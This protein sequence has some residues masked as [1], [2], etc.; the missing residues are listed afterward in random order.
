[1]KALATGALKVDK[2]SSHYPF[3]LTSGAPCCRTTPICGLAIICHVVV[4]GR[5]RGCE[6]VRLLTSEA[7]AASEASSLLSL[8]PKSH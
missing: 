6:A 3:V 1:M 2:L 5:D 7:E 8:R 4:E